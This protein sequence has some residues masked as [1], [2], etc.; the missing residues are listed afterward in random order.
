MLHTAKPRIDKQLKHALESHIP[1]MLVLGED[2]LRDGMVVFKDMTA[3]SRVDVRVPRV[4]IVGMLQ[5]RVEAYR[6][7]VVDRSGVVEALKSLGLGK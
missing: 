2:E 4:E 1:F 3:D 7:S 5:D 6:A